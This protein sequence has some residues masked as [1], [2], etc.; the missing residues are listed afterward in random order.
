MMINV[1][2]YCV[3]LVGLRLLAATFDDGDMSCCMLSYIAV[4]N[5]IVSAASNL[6]S[7]VRRAQ[8]QM[9]HSPQRGEGLRIALH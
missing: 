9:L 3:A 4:V 2:Y 5:A 6:G 7:K 1:P 8:Q